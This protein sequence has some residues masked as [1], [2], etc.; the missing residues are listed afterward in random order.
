ML[1][2][3]KVQIG[4][5]SYSVV[6]SEMAGAKIKN[7]AKNTDCLGLHEPKTQRISLDPDQGSDCEADT[8]LHEV[9]H[10]VWMIGGMQEGAASKHE[11]LV[12]TTLATLLLDT[13]R[14]NPKLVAY[15]TK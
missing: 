7:E 15:L 1:L 4:P 3:D 10:A 5:M 13:L 8:L 12:V 9:L 11:E 14:R 2:P 6:C